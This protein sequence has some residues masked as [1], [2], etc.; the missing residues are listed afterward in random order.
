MDED[1]NRKITIPAGR[2]KQVELLGRVFA[3]D[4][5]T[6]HWQR[7]SG[8]G[9]ARHDVIKIANVVAGAK[10]SFCM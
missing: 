5:I 3:I 10:G 1:M 9:A 7:R 2:K 4:E 6:C 8:R